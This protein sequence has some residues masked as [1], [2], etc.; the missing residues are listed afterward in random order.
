M[1]GS[2]AK[3][4]LELHEQEEAKKEER[5]Q[6]FMRQQE[7]DKEIAAIE[8]DLTNLKNTYELIYEEGEVKEV[9]KG[10]APVIV[11]S[12]GTIHV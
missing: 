2:A 7:L 8:S 3:R 4:I 11:E 9:V 5:A 1:K 6:H 12:N 10:E